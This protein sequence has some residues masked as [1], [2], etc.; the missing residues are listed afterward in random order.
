MLNNYEYFL[1][2]AEELNITRAAEKLFISHQCLSKYLKK[3]ETECGTALFQR[4]PV[5]S[6]TYAGEQL[7]QSLR[8]IELIEKNIRTTM[9]SLQSGDYGEV[10]FGTPEG[11]LRVLMPDLLEQFAKKYPNVDIRMSCASPTELLEMIEANKLDAIVTTDLHTVLSPNIRRKVLLEEHLY[12]IISDNMLREC[13]PDQYPECITRFKEGVNLQE[14]SHVPFVLN[15]P[16]FTSRD[17]LDRFL[18]KTGIALNCV[19]EI[20]SMDLHHLMTARDFAASLALTM[21]LPSIYQLSDTATSYSELYAF[22]IQELK[23]TNAFVMLSLKN[24]LYPQYVQHAMNLLKQ[25]CSNYE[26]YT[27]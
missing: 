7:Y 27:I 17:M 3:L 10:R 25:L 11:R 21:Y 1:V 19:N 9:N 8:Q 13:F 16:G 12:L 5:F 20:N 22:P 2:L 18:L 24:R 23:E 15:H 26:K 4:K 6:M 14:F